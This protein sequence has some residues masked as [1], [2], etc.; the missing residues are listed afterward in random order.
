MTTGHTASL[1]REA[2]T[3]TAMPPGAALLTAFLCLVF[4]ANVVAVKIALTG[5]GTFT[6]AGLRFTLAAV[7]LYLWARFTGQPLAVN[8]SQ[9]LKLSIVT[10]SFIVQLACF[11][12]GFSRTTASHGTLIGNLLPFIV[13][14]LAHFYIPEDR[15]T[16]NKLL[17]LTLGFGGVAF[18]FF[19]PAASSP[20]VRSGDLIVLA[21]VVVWGCNAV[22]VK[23]IIKGFSPI[24]ITLYP[25]AAA[26][27]VFLAAGWMWDGQMVTS[28]SPGVINA[29]I[30][31]SLTASFGF[32][33][34]NTLLRKYGATALHSFVFVMPL[35]GVFAGVTLLGEP[36]TASL[37]ASIVC[38][39]LGIVTVH[40]KPRA[41]PAIP[42]SDATVAPLVLTCP[43]EDPDTGRDQEP[44]KTG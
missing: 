14:V 24:Q 6:S 40:R 33:A 30:Y 29:L 12:L 8:R 25:M 22:Y 23:T 26:T 21:A 38:V 36:L 32:V 42:G 31:Q 18:L 2:C 15:I 35:A 44:G 34:W 3:A 17:G 20:E 11:Y 7:T 10:L 9:G 19:D 43:G 41:V 13:L 28:L 16:L 4:G 37:A 1:S 39:A 5:L 27:P